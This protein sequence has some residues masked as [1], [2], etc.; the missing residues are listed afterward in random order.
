MSLPT[1]PERALEARL[2]A[3][4]ERLRRGFVSGL[5]ARAT[6]LLAARAA[7]QNEEMVR[8]VHQLSGSAAAFGLYKLAATARELE[9]ALLAGHA[10]APSAGLDRL[11]AMLG[12]TE[13]A[14]RR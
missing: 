6:A 14:E 1:P 9:Q 4:M 13:A 11:L 8:L 10:D 12:E 7:R 3:G 2:E 5:A